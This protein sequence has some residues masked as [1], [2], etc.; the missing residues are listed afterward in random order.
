MLI[1]TARSTAMNVRMP[2]SRDPADS[3]DPWWLA[4]GRGVHAPHIPLPYPLVDRGGR[5]GWLAGRDLGRQQQF[6]GDPL[7]PDYRRSRGASALSAPRGT[8][9]AVP[10]AGPPQW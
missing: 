6:L 3:L 10:Q 4:M 8:A 2:F 9:P 1:V 7:W 5:T